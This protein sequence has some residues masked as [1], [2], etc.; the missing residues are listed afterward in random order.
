MTLQPFPLKEGSRTNCDF[1]EMGVIEMGLSAVI[2]G[3][4]VTS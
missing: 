2:A 4:T 1:V 3:T